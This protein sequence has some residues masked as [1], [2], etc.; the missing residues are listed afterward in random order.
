MDNEL[1]V[2]PLTSLALALIPVAI[3]IAIM[4]RWSLNASDGLLAVGRMLLQLI[5]IGFVL[6]WIF[7]ANSPLIV[8]VLLTIMLSVA[9]WISLRPLQQRHW[10]DFGRSFVAITLGGC[11]TL[12]LITAFVLDLQPWYSARQIIPLAGMIF[13][14]AMNSVSLGAE[15]LESELSRETGYRD[16]RRLAYQA[17]LIPLL[18]SLLAVGL[19]SLPGMMTGQILSGVDPLIAV[20]YQIMVMCMLTG[21][22]GISTAIYLA[23]A[24]RHKFNN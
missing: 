8:L 11:F 14:S 3:V 19:V 17:S 20:R 15:R 5:L 6:N 16:A 13:A 2:I 4:V 24:T 18:N 22:S 1:L 9:S 12:A 10:Q 23:L 21:A 7:A